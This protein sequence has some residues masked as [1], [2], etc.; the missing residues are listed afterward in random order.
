MGTIGP[1]IYR[2]NPLAIGNYP[3]DLPP[4]L[5]HPLGTDALGRDVF[6]MFLNGIRNSLYVG[7][8]TAVIATLIGLPIGVVSGMRGGTFLDEVLMGLTNIVLSIPSWLVAILVLSM[9]PSE[10]RGVEIVGAILG[11]FSWPWFA[12]AIRAQF[13][14]FRER[15]FV[16]LS[17]IAGYSDLRVA[18][19]DI[20]PNMGAF[21]LSS[22]TSFIAT[23]IGGEAGL[24][25]IGVGVTKHVSLGMML[26][27]AQVYQAY[28]R[29]AWWY[30]IPAGLTIILLML[31]M[32]LLSL[33]AEIIFNP[34]LRET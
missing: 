22:F 8:I 26:Y 6:A 15:D 2:V 20:L 9:I 4:S 18:F 10:Q 34:R 27:W 24:A 25:V 29:G 3:A 33:G 12:R 31:S 7:F 13:Y 16:Y 23:G 19:E 17:R 1:L 11:L 21:I 28:V 5:E 14:S 30:F 32:Q